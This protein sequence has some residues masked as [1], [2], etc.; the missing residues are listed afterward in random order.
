MWGI[1]GLYIVIFMCLWKSLQVA[2]SVIQAASDFVGSNLR[3]MII[4]VIFF[5]IHI[6]FFVAWTIGAVMVFS[7]GEI[8]NGPPG[9]QFKVIKWNEQ[10]R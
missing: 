7:I 3:V 2:L 10:T 1:S 8:D 4:P 6:A 5:V 9:S